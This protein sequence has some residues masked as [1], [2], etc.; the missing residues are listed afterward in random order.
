MMLTTRLMFV[1]RKWT[2]S[3]SV[4]VFADEKSILTVWSSERR[5]TNVGQ[6]LHRTMASQGRLFTA[7]GD[8]GKNLLQ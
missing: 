6:K 2:Q 4:V 5:S 1:F 3:G 7:V 8:V